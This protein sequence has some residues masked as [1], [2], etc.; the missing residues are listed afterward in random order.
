M[1]LVV[2]V[3]VVGDEEVFSDEEFE[4]EMKQRQKI[5]TQT[6]QVGIISVDVSA[7]QVAVPPTHR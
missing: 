2:V 7:T 6:S 1:N 3:I 4:A 5:V